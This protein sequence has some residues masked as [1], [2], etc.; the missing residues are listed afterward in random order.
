MA[1]VPVVWDPIPC[2]SDP[3]FLASLRHVA[4]VISGRMALALVE[5]Q[6]EPRKRIALIRASVDT[7]FEIESITKALTGMLLADGLHRERLSLDTPV[8]KVV[9]TTNGSE[10]A[11][12]T[13]GELATRT[14]G[15]PRIP[16]GVSCGA[17][18]NALAGRNPLPSLPGERDRHGR[19]P[20]SPRPGPPEVLQPRRSG[21]RQGSG[22]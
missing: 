6:P 14:S 21:P 3:P 10:L 18:P 12:V 20:T 5:L 1:S 8:G 16:G 22:H 17:L 13:L 15:L 4:P 19:I 9:P 7:R 11:T 2:Q